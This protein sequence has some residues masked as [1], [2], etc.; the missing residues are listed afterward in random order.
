M[1]NKLVPMNR[2]EEIELKKKQLKELRERRRVYQ[3][4]S[5]REV[6]QNT[7]QNSDDRKKDA[8]STVSISVQTDDLDGRN[9]TDEAL[10]SEIHAQVKSQ[11][12]TYDKAIQTTAL[13]VENGIFD[14]SPKVSDLIQDHESSGSSEDLDGDDD[15][16]PLSTLIVDSQQNPLSTVSFSLQ[17]VLRGP[18]PGKKRLLSS[19]SN[20]KFLL[21]QDWNPNLESRSGAT[22]Q[23]VSLDYHQDLMVA[24]FQSVPVDRCNVLLTPWSYIMVFKWETAQLVDK[25]D[26]RGQVLIKAM[27]LRKYVAS[28][29]T[30]ILITTQA[31]KTMLYELRCVEDLA[32]K[33]MIERNIISKNLFACPVYAVE[34][35]PSVPIGYERFIAAS[36]NGVLNEFQTLDLS[37]YAEAA[38][39]RPPLCDVKVVPPRPSD[40]L[41]LDDD[42]DDDEEVAEQD[43]PKTV[44]ELFSDHLSKVA[45]YDRLAITAISISPSDPNCVY[46]G[47]EDGGVYKLHLDSVKSSTIK[48]AIDNNGFLPI[49]NNRYLIDESTEVFHS[50]HVI[51]LS[52][53]RDGLLMSSSL[54][55]TCNLWDTSQNSHMGCIDMGSPVI[56][57]QWL[58]EEN[59]LCGILTWNTFSIVQWHYRSNIN[60]KT[61]VRQWQW[62]SAPSIIHTLSVEQA[63]CENF[64][65]FKAFKEGQSSQL[66]A[67]GCDDHKVRFY[68]LPPTT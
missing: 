6:L 1:R 5:I 44:E 30:S 7:R 27:F 8:H 40:L 24:T 25:I 42:S 13:L 33:K 54:D 53:N 22:L 50:S 61:M 23:C 10:S 18:L 64:T 14:R 31:G 11:V 51:A 56:D 16:V 60:N 41:V 20:S 38:S 48:V 2:L 59:K 65:C 35:F 26:F 12:I 19:I 15:V 57:S 47:T 39:N 21:A 63:S 34:E 36:V 3:S 45:L 43:L 29:V 28:N 37:I 49:K 52:H 55:W 32:S 67:L 66:V 9:D 17:E 62:V 58:D 4:D 68:R 46:V